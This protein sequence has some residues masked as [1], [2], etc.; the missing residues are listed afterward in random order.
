[1]LDS[2]GKADAL[3]SEAKPPHFDEILGNF[4]DTLL[5]FVDSEVWPMY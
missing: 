2:G 4:G 5:A 3:L 1:M